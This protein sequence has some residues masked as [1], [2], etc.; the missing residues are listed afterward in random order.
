MA[1]LGIDDILAKGH[2]N[3]Y[4]LDD[5]RLY[6]W[7][8][9]DQTRAAEIHELVEAAD[10][11]RTIDGAPTLTVVAVDPE[12]FLNSIQLLSY[13]CVFTLDA[14]AYELVGVKKSGD[15]FTMTFEDVRVAEMRRQITPRKVPANTLSRVEFAYALISELPPTDF[16]TPSIDLEVTHNE[17]ARG[18]DKPTAGQPPEDTWKALT[19]I[20][21][22]VKWRFWVDGGRIFAAPD[23][24]LVGLPPTATI[25]EHSGGVDNIDFDLDAGKRIQK[26]TITAVSDRWTLPIGAHIIF[27]DQGPT[28]GDWIIS[29]FRRSLFG[30]MATITAVKPVFP[31]V[32]PVQDASSAGGATPAQK[33]AIDTGPSPAAPGEDYKVY[34]RRQALA[35]YGWDDAEFAAI[36][37]IWNDESG[38]RPDAQNPSSTAFGIAQFLDSTWSGTGID[39]TPDGYRQIDAGL[40][41]LEQRYGTPQKALA[42]RKVHGWY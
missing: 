18:K 11:V 13:R 29:E 40:I 39:K 4:S 31:L 22:E 12:R 1:V 21:N 8:S 14:L 34:A 35:L 7:K 25:A 30:P 19:R 26:A 2:V 17:L 32:E 5:F 16:V 36:D 6:G 33:A 28:G 24:Y 27:N 9:N 38:W 23:T 15:A 10:I 41:Y 20:F 3:D 37:E 42:F